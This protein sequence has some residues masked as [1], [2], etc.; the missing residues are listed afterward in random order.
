MCRYGDPK[1]C[2]DKND[3]AF[4]QRFHKECSL[5][6][7]EASLAQ[8]ATLAG[9]LGESLMAAD[10]PAIVAHKR[11]ADARLCDAAGE[12]EAEAA[13]AVPAGECVH[14]YR[15]CLACEPAAHMPLASP[16]ASA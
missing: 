10:L 16:H 7:L 4:A 12:A 1:L 11:Q 2:S 3:I 13:A 6:F 8:L 5:T 9:A 14:V 15:R